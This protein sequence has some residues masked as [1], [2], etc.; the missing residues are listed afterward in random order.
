MGG[1]V[2][3]RRGGI[4]QL[5]IA[6]AADLDLIDTLDEARWAATSAPVVQFHCDP[7]FLEAMD[8]D[9]DG[10]IRVEDVVA[11]RDWLWARLSNRGAAET[12]SDRLTL[13]DLD[14]SHDDSAGMRA[15][16]ELL[17]VRTAGSDG[18]TISLDDVRTRRARHKARFPNGDG[19]VTP[20]QVSG[21]LAAAV[22]DILTVLPGVT[23]L[24]G[25]A[26]V[27]RE[28]VEAFR[29]R[30]AEIVGWRGRADTEPELLPL[31]A[32]TRAAAD[33]VERLRSKIDQFFSQSELLAFVPEASL[34]V[35][36]AADAVDTLDILDLG[37]I[38]AFLDAAPLS[39]PGPSS[40][41]P[42]HGR[43]NPRDA[44]DLAAFVATVT[45]P[46][47]GASDTL[48]RAQWTAIETTFAPH[49]AWRAA[50]PA[51]LETWTDAQLA[52][53]ADRA[54]FE[55][56]ARLTDDDLDVADELV[57]F[58]NLERLILLQRWLLTF[59]NNFV[60]FP[61]L[62]DPE[63]RALFEMGT[64]VLDGRRL[65]L[66]TLVVDRDAHRAIA[67][68]SRMFLV[69]AELSRREGDTTSTAVVAA[70]VTSGSRGGI[71][72]GKRGVFYD[73]EGVEWDARVLEV[74]VEPIS[75]LEAM[76]APFRKLADRLGRRLEEL[77]EEKASA[78]DKVSLDAPP[79]LGATPTTAAA[80]PP[81]PTASSDGRSNLLMG[82]TVA[83]A[84][85]GSA[86]TYIVETLSSIDLWS[87]LWTVLAL[88][89]APLVFGAIHGWLQLRRR[90]LSAVLEAGGWALNG[91]MLLTTRLGNVFTV[92]PPLPRGSA[93]RPAPLAPAVGAVAA[94][95]LVGLITYAAWLL[96]TRLELAP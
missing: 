47:V 70:A 23:D 48:T 54:A 31:G 59:A 84:A 41:L 90:D 24:S 57:H 25:K 92:R 49:F 11:A 27:R 37:A 51:G 12:G 72:T 74:I 77:T 55:D 45:Q 43:I 91:R 6:S 73:R 17:L 39:P 26:G 35:E 68:T 80:A 75:I 28:D 82:G 3:W 4:Y 42:L 88:A 2:F 33:L 36:E 7:A 76:L 60:S 87:A 5:Q 30:V 46:L 58:A 95:A 38:A 63:A 81:A 44:A 79:S 66:V 1:W 9:R 93:L 53:V 21:D 52:G 85:A 64:L 15:L 16:A 69:Y 65:N 14:E 8:R 61:D 67:K 20:D 22:A 19:V 78:L 62:F 83:V 29:V 40:V 18:L 10:R 89:A 32:D 34:R 13:A 50:R 71:D 96:Y 56:V 94:V 86:A